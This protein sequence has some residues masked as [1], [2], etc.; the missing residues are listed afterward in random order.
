MFC[1]FVYSSALKVFP[2]STGLLQIQ[3]DGTCVYSSDPLETPSPKGGT[4]ANQPGSY[5]MSHTGEVAC[6]I[7]DADGNHFQVS[8]EDFKKMGL[9]VGGMAV[10]WL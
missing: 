1:L 8:Y 4:P 2:F 10:E 5:T 6:D 3:S 7:T 9:C